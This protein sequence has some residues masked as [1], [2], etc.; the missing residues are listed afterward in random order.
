MP[1]PF[2]PSPSATGDADVLVDGYGRPFRYATVNDDTGQ[3]LKTGFEFTSDGA[4][5]GNVAD[6]IKRGAIVEQKFS[7]S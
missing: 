3:S 1:P 6:D 4:D 7:E 5:P 2:S